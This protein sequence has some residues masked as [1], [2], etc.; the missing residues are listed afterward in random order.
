MVSSVSGYQGVYVKRTGDKLDGCATFYKTEK[1]TLEE[2]V[3][4]EYF[5][6]NCSLLDR[7]NVGLIVK[8]RPN[9]HPYLPEDS[10][11]IANT[12]LLFNPRRGDVKLAQVMCL[13]AEVDKVSK[14]SEDARCQVLVCGDFNATPLS[15]L[16]KFII[17]GYLK[18]EGLMT[19]LISG[20][21]EGQFRGSNRCLSKNFFPSCHKI[22]DQ[23]RHI[24]P[25]EK[26]KNSLRQ[27]DLNHHNCPSI[28]QSSGRLWHHLNLVSTYRHTIERL[29]HREGEVTTQHSADRCIVDYIFYGVSNRDVH[30]RRSKHISTN[31]QEGKLKLLG[32]WGL[33]SAREIRELGDLPNHYHPSDHLPLVVKM[34]LV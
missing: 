16:F 31:V 29:G 9:K 1:F 13:L 4:I 23:C 33:M 26:C 8:L 3:P 12:H 7:D 19:R 20:Q 5:K 6:S 10:L 17:H 15:D 22:S 27:E 18:Y 11:C 14:T 24:K 28:S 34:L 30:T 32:R 2:S 25:Y 21:S